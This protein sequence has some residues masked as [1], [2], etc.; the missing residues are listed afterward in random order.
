MTWLGNLRIFH[1]LDVIEEGLHLMA[2][3]VRKLKGE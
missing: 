2:A 1:R 3:D